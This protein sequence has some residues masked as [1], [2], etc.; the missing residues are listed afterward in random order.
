[1]LPCPDCPLP[2]ESV[3]DQLR[4]ILIL[5]IFTQW[6][7]EFSMHPPCVSLL[8]TLSWPYARPGLAQGVSF[9]LIDK[10]SCFVILVTR[11]F[12]IIN[13]MIEQCI[14]FMPFRNNILELI[15]LILKLSLF[16]Y[17]PK[18]YF[19]LIVAFFPVYLL[20]LKSELFEG[21]NHFP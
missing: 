17:S 8:P 9:M 3:L 12:S 2:A 13:Y 1:M 5:L 14:S 10:M 15:T 19:F 16:Y 7:S 6:Q 11:H 18:L 20:A 21:K 4:G